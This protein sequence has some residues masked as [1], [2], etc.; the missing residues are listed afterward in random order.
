MNFYI[1]YKPINKISNNN[2]LFLDIINIVGYLNYIINRYI[3]LALRFR[4]YKI[5]SHLYF[6]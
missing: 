1:L 6:L 5:Y 3:Y 4:Y 2:F